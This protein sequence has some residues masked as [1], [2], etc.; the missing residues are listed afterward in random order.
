MVSV[1]PLVQ[2]YWG[3][4]SFHHTPG[5]VTRPGNVVDVGTLDM[6]KESVWLIGSMIPPY[7]GG[8][9]SL[10]QG[11]QP[12]VEAYLLREIRKPVELLLVRTTE[13]GGEWGEDVVDG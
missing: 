9:V 12:Y 8:D 11:I 1:C 6:A 10:G 13:D 5:L 2:A 7:G 3:E 4:A